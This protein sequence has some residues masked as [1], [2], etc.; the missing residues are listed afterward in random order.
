MAR[1]T[2]SC[3]QLQEQHSLVYRQVLP[4]LLGIVEALPLSLEYVTFPILN[5]LVWVV[6]G[7]GL[8]IVPG[9]LGG[10]VPPV[11]SRAIALIF[12]PR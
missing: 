5:V 3:Q 12:L 10:S 7:L 2:V 6:T 1:V 9:Q 11:I 4:D 8:S